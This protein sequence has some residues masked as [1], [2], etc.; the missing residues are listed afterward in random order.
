MPVFC[1]DSGLCSAC[2]LLYSSNLPLCK[3]FSFFFFFLF[4]FDSIL[5]I[6]PL[7]DGSQTARPEAGM[8][9]REQVQ[10]AAP[11][12]PGHGRK[13]GKRGLTWDPP[14]R[15]PQ[16][17]SEGWVR[18]C[19]SGSG[20]NP[21]VRRSVGEFHGQHPAERQHPGVLVVQLD[22]SRQL[23]SAREP[24]LLLSLMSEHQQQSTQLCQTWT[25]ARVSW[26]GGS[27]STTTPVGSLAPASSQ[28][29]PREVQ[30]SGHPPLQNTAF[31]GGQ[32]PVP[33][34]N[35]S[36]MSCAQTPGSGGRS[37]HR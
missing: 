17:S 24:G 33:G 12:Q 27:T 1:T 3:Y 5:C 35:G 21:A 30:P 26:A 2:C 25:E 28:P 19:G 11:L 20:P 29:R 31:H 7:S 10:Q 22:P 34:T 14:A 18:H 13:E 15:I 9:H 16:S 8:L 32:W 37:C 36:D 6:S 4:Y 23:L